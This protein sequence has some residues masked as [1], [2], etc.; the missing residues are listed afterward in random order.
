MTTRDMRRTIAEQKRQH[1]EAGNM[2]KVTRGLYED[3][4]PNLSKFLPCKTFLCQVL[5]SVSETDRCI[6][7][8]SRILFVPCN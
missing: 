7:A 6:A 4:I 3:G 2:V 8:G 1:F 5:H